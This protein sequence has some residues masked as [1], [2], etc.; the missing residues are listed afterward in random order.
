MGFSL[1]GISETDDVVIKY[2]ELNPDYGPFRDK[3][4]Q[5]E[6]LKIASHAT[7]NVP[8]NDADKETIWQACVKKPAEI[9]P[10]FFLEILFRLEELIFG[11]D[12]IGRNAHQL[13]RKLMQKY[14]VDPN[15]GI[16]EWHIQANQFNE[17]IEHV[18]HAALVNRDVPCEKY[19]EHDM[20]EILDYALPQT[21]SEKLFNIDWDIY[22]NPYKKT[23]HKPVALEPEIKAERAKEK[24]N[25]ELKD[26][27]YGTKGTK[28]DSNGKP[29]ASDGNSSKTPCK[30]CNKVHKA[31][32][33]FKNGGGGGNA[34]CNNRNSDKGFS[35]K[36]M[37]QMMNKMFKSHSPTKES[38][39]ES[40]TTAD[41][42]KKNISLVHQIYIAQQFKK[43][44]SMDSD[45]DNFEIDKE[46]VKFYLKKAKKAEKSL[47]RS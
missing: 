20:R 10:L 11:K 19:K 46:E 24:E 25:K 31:E 12:M 2:T 36:Q 39:S 29:R 8:M 38:D 28:C 43:D 15:R 27:V 47:K 26:K 18:P 22:E 13:L 23:I 45:D 37:V 9:G 34:G 4:T 41:G 44:N 21:Y 1:L 6:L 30:T 7:T 33:W 32:C 42:W 17:Y 5:K 35:K 3:A 40:K 14:A 16:A